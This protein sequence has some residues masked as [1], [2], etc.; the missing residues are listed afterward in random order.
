M[1]SQLIGGQGG[2]NCVAAV[3]YVLTAF[4]IALQQ[5]WSVFAMCVA[6]DKLNILITTNNQ[7]LEII[8]TSGQYI[9]SVQLK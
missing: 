1:D 5:V 6:Y 4:L 3:L 7:T 9:H 2:S 8:L